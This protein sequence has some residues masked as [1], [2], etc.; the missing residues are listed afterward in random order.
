MCEGRGV[1]LGCERGWGGVVKGLALLGWGGVRE[2]ARKGDGGVWEGHLKRA[3][4]EH[5]GVLLRGLLQLERLSDGAHEVGVDIEV[6]RRVA[7]RSLL[8]GI[9]LLSQQETAHV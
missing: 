8:G 3:R 5:G 6:L 7:N 9:Q 4:L 1:V 2:A